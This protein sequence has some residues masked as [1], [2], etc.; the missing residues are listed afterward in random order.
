MPKAT[1]TDQRFADQSHFPRLGDYVCGCVRG[2]RHSMP[3]RSA[4]ERVSGDEARPGGSG[5]RHLELL[6][7]AV[8]NEVF[9]AIQPIGRFKTEGRRAR[10]SSADRVS[11]PAE[12]EIL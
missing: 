10:D 5:R 2:R 7:T 8:T 3:S 4:F 12:P 11:L 9:R 1:F 6:I